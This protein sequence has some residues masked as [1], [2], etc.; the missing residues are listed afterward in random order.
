MRRAEGLV[1]IRVTDDGPGIPAQFHDR[2]FEIF[3]T[4]AS[5]DRV[6]SSGM[7]L[8]IVKKMIEV[9]GG[10]VWIESAAPARGTTVAFSWKE[11]PA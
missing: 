6:E 8:A 2:V 11:E 3:Q 10:R 9:H 4:L 5:R 7:G 1:E